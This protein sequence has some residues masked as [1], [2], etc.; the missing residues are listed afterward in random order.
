MSSSDGPRRRRR[1][2]ANELVTIYWRDIPAQVTATVNGEKGSWV[3][4][5]RFEKSIDNAATIAGLTSADDYVQEW[6][7]VSQP[8]EGSDPEHLARTEAE[9]LQDLYPRDRLRELAGNG[10]LEPEPHER[11]P[12]E[13]S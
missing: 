12:E 7:R 13:S 1:A 8:C 3:L 6:R 5:A 10:G 2:K 11:S 4:E 9:R